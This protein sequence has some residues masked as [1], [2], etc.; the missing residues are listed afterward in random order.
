MYVFGDCFL[1]LFFSPFASSV[2][3][4]LLP[5]TIFI[6]CYI[7]VWFV[8]QRSFVSI[9]IWFDLYN[10]RLVVRSLALITATTLS[11]LVLRIWIQLN[12]NWAFSLL[13]FFYSLLLFDIIFILCAYEICVWVFFLSLLYISSFVQC[14]K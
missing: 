3:F 10:F 6:R 8:S 1:F 9:L 7:F 2:S 14:R 11:Y 5:I 13:F 4:T 12:L